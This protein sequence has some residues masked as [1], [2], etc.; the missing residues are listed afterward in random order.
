MAGPKHDLHAKY[1][2]HQLQR[3]CPRCRSKRCHRGH[4]TLVAQHVAAKVMPLFKQAADQAV[5]ARKEAAT[6]SGSE[7][8]PTCRLLALQRRQHSCT[9]GWR[10]SRAAG[11]PADRSP[12]HW[13][14]MH[15]HVDT[16]RSSGT[17]HSPGRFPRFQRCSSGSEHAGDMKQAERLLAKQFEVGMTTLKRHQR[18]GIELWLSSAFVSASCWMR[19]P[20]WLPTAAGAASRELRVHP[21]SGGRKMVQNPCTGQSQGQEPGRARTAIST[22]TILFLKTMT[23]AVLS[24]AAAGTGSDVG[25]AGDARR[26]AA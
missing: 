3:F 17:R 5:G 10:V 6:I 19:R 8:Q 14:N 7:Q 20:P 24:L 22:L 4:H 18:P 21:R 2:P 25:A 26:P 16:L 9:I 15:A 1:A 23:S 11:G 13:C 12:M